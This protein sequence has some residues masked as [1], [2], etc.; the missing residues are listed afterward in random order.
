MSTIDYDIMYL[1]V[2]VGVPCL[3]M[4]MYSNLADHIKLLINGMKYFQLTSSFEYN[5]C[6]YFLGYGL[7]CDRI[8]SDRLQVHLILIISRISYQRESI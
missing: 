8:I 2:A 4:V 5:T 3:G 6:L 1:H 7:K